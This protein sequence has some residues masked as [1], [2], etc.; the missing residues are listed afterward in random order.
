MINNKYIGSS[1]EDFFA[2]MG[3]LDEVRALAVEKIHEGPRDPPAAG[4]GL[5]ELRTGR[6]M[7]PCPA[8]RRL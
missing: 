1:V 7:G 6:I 5:P 3:Q 2:E 8:T 4:D